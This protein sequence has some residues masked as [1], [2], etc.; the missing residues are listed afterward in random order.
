MRVYCII[1]MF[2]KLF[3]TFYLAANDNQCSELLPLV[4]MAL[5]CSV[6]YICL[7]QQEDM[8]VCLEFR[9]RL[10][11]SRRMW[12]KAWIK[13]T[14]RNVE[15]SIQYRKFR[16]FVS[17]SLW[18]VWFTL[19]SFVYSHMLNALYAEII[20]TEIIYW[21]VL[22]KNRHVTVRKNPIWNGRPVQR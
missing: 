13:L 22:Q 9:Y 16:K 2:K 14:I 17:L 8:F 1:V 6:L 21:N 7:L 19:C 11:P 20:Y 12:Q 5:F 15:L 10:I 3:I 4:R 18:Q